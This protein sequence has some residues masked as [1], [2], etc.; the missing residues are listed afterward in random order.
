[1]GP[2][3]ALVPLSVKV[4]F[5]KLLEVVPGTKRL[6]RTLQDDH[7]DL[8]VVIG[9]CHRVSN[10]R[11]HPVV[12]RVEPIGTVER[13]IRFTTGRLVLQ[14]AKSV[15]IGPVDRARLARNELR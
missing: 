11:R 2:R 7:T 3:R 15:I 9:C 14:V 5:G 6:A 10:V 12:D 13:D 4:A 8:V 1:M